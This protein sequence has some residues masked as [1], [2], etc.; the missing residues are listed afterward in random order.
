[1]TTLS[2]AVLAAAAHGSRRTATASRA[3]PRGATRTIRNG[4]EWGQSCCARIVVREDAS[5]A[6]ARR[7]C[8]GRSRGR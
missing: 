2:A 3:A 8:R 4:I 7:Q 1:M 5:H 6:T